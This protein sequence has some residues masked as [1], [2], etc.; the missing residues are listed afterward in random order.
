MKICV[1]VAETAERLEELID[2]ALRGDEIVVCRVGN[3]VAVIMAVRK[4]E[5]GTIDDFL[6]LAVEG[7]PTSND[8]TSNRDDLY[9]ENGLP[10]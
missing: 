3:P 1:E 4:A 5:Q 8:L 7:R 10:T 2:L 6:A 9:G